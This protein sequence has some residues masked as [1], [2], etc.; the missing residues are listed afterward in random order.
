MT[1][2]AAVLRQAAALLREL[3][4]KATEFNPLPWTLIEHPSGDTALIR[5]S[6]GDSLASGEFEDGGDF[7]VETARWVAAMSPAVAEPLAAWLEKEADN[8]ERHLPHWGSIPGSIDEPA[9]I[10]TPEDTAATVRHHF[11]HALDVAAALLSRDTGKA[12]P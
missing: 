12:T 1:D 5:S 10:R 3:A 8:L 9:I 2:L 7:I 4:A 6:D 11:G